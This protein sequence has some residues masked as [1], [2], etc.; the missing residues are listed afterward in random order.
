MTRPILPLMEFIIYEDYIAEFLCV[1]KDN[2][3]LQCNGKCYLM[4]MLQEQN[5]DKKQNLP[6]IAMEE[7][8]IGFVQLPDFI[9]EKFLK[10]HD[11]QR[12]KYMNP[13][14]YIFSSESFHP[15]SISC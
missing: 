9:S 11:E 5:E 6:K 7:Y 3:E 2:K 1:N 10:V 8:P 12:F 14:S 13:Y 4:Q 15:P